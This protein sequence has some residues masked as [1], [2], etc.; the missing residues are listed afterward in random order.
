[1]ANLR[2][3]RRT[4]TRQD[5]PDAIRA[6]PLVGM[7]DREITASRN[8]LGKIECHGGGA[9]CGCTRRCR[10]Q[11]RRIGE[12]FGEELVSRRSCVHAPHSRR[13]ARHQRAR[14]VA[15]INHGH[16][17]LTRAALQIV[18]PRPPT[19]NQA[20]IAQADTAHATLPETAA[21]GAHGLRYA[22]KRWRG[23]NRATHRLH[24]ECRWVKQVRR[25][26]RQSHSGKPSLLPCYG[27][28]LGDRIG[29]IARIAAAAASA[30]IAPIARRDGE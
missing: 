30:W 21:I 15:R 9:K 16:K 10:N 17:A 27:L 5:A 25:E 29:R 2:C 11:R 7:F 22:A 8:T 13:L 24:L 6:P 1:M 12:R 26:N 19:V 20:A 14:L 3:D 18:F 28:G 4:R 23:R